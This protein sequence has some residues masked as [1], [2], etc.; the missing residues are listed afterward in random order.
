MVGLNDFKHLFQPKCLSD[1]ICGAR[2]KILKSTAAMLIPL[3]VL[4]GGR[5]K[6]IIAVY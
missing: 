4:Q 6:F 5:M 2:N 3:S 1:M